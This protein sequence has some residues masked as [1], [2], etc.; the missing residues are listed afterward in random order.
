MSSQPDLLGAALTYAGLGLH[1]FPCIPRAKLPDGRLV[2][3][4]VKNASADEW[5]IRAW[6]QRSPSANVAIAI[7]IGALEA[8]RVFDVD[9]KNGGD[10]AFAELVARHGALPATP[11]QI[12]GSGGLHALFRCPT[13]DWR[14]KLISD[15]S[16]LELLGPGRYFVAE[17]SIHP[18][19]GRRYAWRAP[20]ETPIAPA[21]AWLLALANRG[22]GS[23]NRR[24]YVYAVGVGTRYAEAALHRECRDLAASPAGARNDRLN[25]AAFSLARFVASGELSQHAVAAELADA[26]D[27]AGL[28]GSEV[29]RTIASGLRAGLENVR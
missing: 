8:V 29:A 3:H 13:G 15:N 2:P 19:T 16:G 6:W 9:P 14:T 1:V 27:V 4:G 7:G 20:F 11:Q 17:P 25:R 28:R 23:A 26:A 10:R 18:D 24:R 12:S 21:P 22:D 5:T